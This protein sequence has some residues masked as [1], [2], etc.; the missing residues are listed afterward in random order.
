MAE[1]A[2]ISR[3]DQ[4]LGR[5]V[6]LQGW[7]QSRTDKGRLQFLSFRDGTGTIQVVVFEKNVSPEAF[8]AARRVTQESSCEVTG[9][10]RAD[11]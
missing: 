10:V 3:I 9:T 2:T 4:F 6:H 7:L 1:R 8:E 5:Q 11:P